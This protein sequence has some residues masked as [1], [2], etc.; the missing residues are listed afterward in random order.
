MASNSD[1]SHNSPR[2]SLR[3]QPVIEGAPVTE[4]DESDESFLGPSADTTS[5]PFVLFL[6]TRRSHGKVLKEALSGLVASGALRLELIS[7]AAPEALEQARER[8]GGIPM[9]F[10]A[11]DEVTALDALSSGADEVLLWPPRDNAALYGFFDRTKLRASLRMGQARRN[12]AAAHSEKLASLGTL[13]AGVAHEINN[14]LTVIRFGLEACTTFVTPMLKVAHELQTWATQGAGASPEA[15]RKLSLQAE[16]G[17]PPHEDEELLAEM[18][19]ATTSIANIVRDLRIFSRSDSTVEELRLIDPNEAIDHAL[20]LVGRQVSSVALVER[21]FGRDLSQ[22]LVPEGRLT[23]VLINILV[24]AAHAIEEVKRPLHRVRISTRSD[25]EFIAISVEDTG[26]GIAPTAIERI[27]DPFFTTKRA[28]HGTG[29]GLSI[30][31]SIMRSMGGDLLVESVHGSGATFVL[32][33][34]IPDPASTDARQSQVSLHESTRL[35]L[36]QR[37]SVLLVDDD[38]LILSAYAR[39]LSRSFEVVMA[40]D[41]REAIELLESGSTPD[42]VVTELALPLVD[43]Q[44]LFHWLERERPE[45]AQSM[46][47]VTAEATAHRYRAFLD[48]AQSVVLLKP[49]TTTDLINALAGA[50]REPLS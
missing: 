23:Q 44:E 41:G 42:I 28:G 15:I 4:Y 50:E 34:P 39:A 10:I 26:P 35:P 36:G 29:L 33:L 40:A 45:L 38:N 6:L 2:G 17:S 25:G 24:N 5:E 46:I 31:R 14:P 48:S 1:Q 18:L 8:L 16:T 19:A 20:R 49:V 9:G 3:L 32:L 12:A 21:D 47:F 22:V 37:K 27:F 7:Q 30:S 11:D 43:G 13:V